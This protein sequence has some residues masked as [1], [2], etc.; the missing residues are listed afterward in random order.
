[1]RLRIFRKPTNTLIALL[2]MVLTGALIATANATASPPD[3]P[4]NTAAD[5]EIRQ[6]EIQGPSSVSDRTALA[7][8]GVSLDEVHDHSVVVSAD[9]A[10][11]ASCASSG[12][13]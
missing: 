10:Q 1:M 5:E 2:A 12:T 4:S 7:A 6:Y 8:T 9:S 13:S 11:A 3:R